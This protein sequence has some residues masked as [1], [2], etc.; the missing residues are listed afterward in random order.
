MKPH[1]RFSLKA[2]ERIF[3]NG[4]VLSVD[5]KVTLSLLNDATFLLESHVLQVNDATTPMRQLYFVVQAL[6]ISPSTKQQ[7]IMVFRELHASLLSIYTDDEVKEALDAILGL[8]NNNRIFDALKMIRSLFEADDHK[9]TP[10]TQSV[11]HAV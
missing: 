2:G 4:A 7:T 1:M 5:Q 10:A 11:H 9:A 8:V 3:I 6:L